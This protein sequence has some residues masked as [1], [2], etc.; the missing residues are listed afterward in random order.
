MG[1]AAIPP[2]RRR[3][4][5]GIGTRK[6]FASSFTLSFE[7]CQP[8]DEAGGYR[9]VVAHS[10]DQGQSFWFEYDKT[11]LAVW[12]DYEDGWAPRWEAYGLAPDTWYT[13][14]VQNELERVHFSIRDASGAAVA[15]SPG[16][17]TM[18]LAPAR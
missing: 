2:A 16:C 7:F 9:A 11:A 5:C 1:M 12:T 18:W 6:S 13:V 4:Q 8:A 14:T 10:A 17:R 15:E 3:A